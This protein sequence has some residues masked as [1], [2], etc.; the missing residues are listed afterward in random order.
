[1]IHKITRVKYQWPSQPQLDD[2]R[3]LGCNIAPVGFHH[4]KKTNVNPDNE[5]EW[6]VFYTKAE[7]YLSRSF[8]H[9]KVRVYLFCLIVFKC[10]FEKF[11]GIKEKH[12]RHI[13][14]R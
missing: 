11:E 4:P 13:L 14:Y 9:P 2:I 1:M 5:I 8:S 3:R 12:L 10:Y 7:Q 6:E